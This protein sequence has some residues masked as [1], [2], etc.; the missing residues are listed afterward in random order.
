MS[1]SSRSCAWGRLVFKSRR[2]DNV[3]EVGGADDVNGILT[4]SPFADVR[5]GDSFKI[6]GALCDLP[7]RI[8]S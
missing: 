8:A 4:P 5:T 7:S 6:V 3:S 2:E 1:V